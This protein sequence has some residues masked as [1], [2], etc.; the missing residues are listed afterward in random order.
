MFDGSAVAKYMRS[1]INYSKE[2]RL[3]IDLDAEKGQTPRINKKT[4][5]PHS[6]TVRVRITKAKEI[7]L[8]LL[9]AYVEKGTDFSLHILE[10]IS[11]SDPLRLFE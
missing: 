7:N 5:Q 4:G 2:I 3:L 11:L 1:P 8:E 10:C 9:R 6:N